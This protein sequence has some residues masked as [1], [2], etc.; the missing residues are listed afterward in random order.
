M[1]NAL[2]VLVVLSAL[3]PIGCGDAGN[4][5][6]EGSAA[7]E[8]A[9]AGLQGSGAAASD[10][11]PAGPVPTVTAE[12]RLEER[13]QGASLSVAVAGL[14]PGE[15]YPVHVH[16]GTCQQDG[17]VRL[18]LGRVTAGGDG[19][20]SVRMTVG[21]GRLPDAPLFVEVLGQDGTPTACA[22]VAVGPSSQ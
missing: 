12:A 3:V 13:E 17:P 16:E 7:A 4:P 8:S 20:G 18:P 22:D 6:G 11:A 9:A 2:S 1:R 14:T 15:R 5:E 21:E 10:A 19:T